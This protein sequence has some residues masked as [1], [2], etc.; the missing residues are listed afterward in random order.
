MMI[1][2]TVRVGSVEYKVE[3]S[4]TPIVMNGLQCLG[5]CDYFNHIIKI[6]NTMSDPQTQEIT[7]LH[8]VTHAMFAERKIQLESYVD[9]NT[10]EF[11]V[12]SFAYM[13][14]QLALDNPDIFITLDVLKDLGI[15][16]PDEKEEVKVIATDEINNTI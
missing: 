4:D 10:V 14:H 5:Y 13:L 11:L 1:P 7:F 15:E 16:L 9:E 6:D 3:F 8:E 2:D 12:D